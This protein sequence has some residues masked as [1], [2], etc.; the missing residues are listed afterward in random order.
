M[1][2]RMCAHEIGWFFLTLYK[3]ARYRTFGNMNPKREPSYPTDGFPYPPS[4][5]MG[6]PDGKEMYIPLHNLAQSGSLVP[7]NG[8]Q[9]VLRQTPSWQ[10]RSGGISMP[11]QPM[12]FV[13]QQVQS[14]PYLSA[15]GYATS[16]PHGPMDPFAQTGC[17]QAQA[18]VQQCDQCSRYFRRTQKQSALIIVLLF[19]IVLLVFRLMDK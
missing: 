19:V 12:R 13:P 2:V 3:M 10:P 4:A 16:S 11:A 15:G 1:S 9:V 18:H 5:P 17:A 6:L 7:H 14:S 8:T